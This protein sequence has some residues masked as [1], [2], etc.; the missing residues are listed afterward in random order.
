M[1]GYGR[2]RYRYNEWGELTE[3]RDQQLE[4]N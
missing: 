3:R 2:D 1:P 4:W